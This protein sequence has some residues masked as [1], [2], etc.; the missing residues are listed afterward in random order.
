MEEKL[1]VLVVS[2]SENDGLYVTA[3]D[4]PHTIEWLQ[5]LVD[6][7]HKIYGFEGCHVDVY[8]KDAD[9]ADFEVNYNRQWESYYRNLW[10][11]WFEE[12]FVEE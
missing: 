7:I 8:L 10:F 2:K 4:M 9:L 3:Y 1:K 5:R 6:S 11:D 12:H